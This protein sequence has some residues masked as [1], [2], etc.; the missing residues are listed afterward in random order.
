MEVDV[1][2]DEIREVET[3][4]IFLQADL[5]SLLKKQDELQ[6]RKQTLEQRK[7]SLKRISKPL[8]NIPS[9][10]LRTHAS[11]LITH[12][13]T[14]NSCTN[15]ENGK[16]PWSAA[17]ATTL[18][19][20]FNIDQFRPLQ[21]SCVN[22]TLSNEDTILI[23]PTGGGKSLC[24]QLPAVLSQGL[25]LVISPLVSL[26]EDQLLAV[27]NLGIQSS[28]LNASTSREE[29]T[30][31]QAAM[32]E[33]G[34]SLKI[35][36]V[37]PE[38]ISK[39]KR[40][41]SKLEKSYEVGQLSRIVIDEVHCAS[42]WGHDFRPDYKILGILKRQ[43]PSVPLLGLTATATAQVVEDLKKMLS[44]KDCLLFR[45]PYNRSNLFYEVRQKKSGHKPQMEALSA[46][47][48]RRFPSMSGTCIVGT[49]FALH[50]CMFHTLAQ[51][52][53]RLIPIPVHVI[54]DIP[55]RDAPGLADRI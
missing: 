35:L 34:S 32:A 30:R 36:Y 14:T 13:T 18:K 11:S 55:F 6:K 29:V 33:K 52:P 41:M 51:F 38:K 37:T 21:S 2:V 50:F 44:L 16:F 9:L 53:F 47:I 31:I 39:S 8:E 27:K 5:E 46:L 45:A 42:Q 20:T 24:Y 1:L 26:M 10:D 23:M 48:K 54:C 22:A 28:T 15:W 25:T 43:F 4:L 3:E 49:C 40:F 12:N 17:V 19:S 7:D